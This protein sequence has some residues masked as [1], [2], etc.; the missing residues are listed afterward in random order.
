VVGVSIAEV[1]GRAGV[2]VEVVARV[3][4]GGD[5]PPDAAAAVWA[6]TRD[7]G[8]LD[9]AAVGRPVAGRP[10]TVAV[11]VSFT[12]RWFFTE[13]L[14]SVR[15]MLEWVGARTAIY[16]LPDINRRTMFFDQLPLRG[17]IDAVLVVSLVLTDAEFHTLARLG[18]PLGVLGVAVPGMLSTRIDDVAGARTAVEH[19]IG[20]GHER[21]ALIGDDQNAPMRYVPPRDRRAGYQQALTSA[22]LLV[23]PRL[24]V[25]GGF[26]PPGGARAAQILLDAP[27]PPSA[28]FCG[29]DEMAWGAVT[30]L[31]KRGLHVP[32]DV[33]V[34]G[35]DDHPAAALMDLS[36]IRQPVAAQA[37]DLT[38]RLLAQLAGRDA[39]EDEF[40]VVLPT[41]LVIRASTDLA[42]VTPERGTASPAVRG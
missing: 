12:D 33:A 31:V 39:G 10:V 32:H 11:L 16:H 15:A 34:I 17:D 9:W 8:F 23:D 38:T 7:V 6:A 41:E 36:T 1:A 19:L 18:V 3:L 24:D 14:S 30:T 35:Y 29:S 28:I 4:C 2:P 40:D 5:V 26:T 20:A 37:L 27:H 22:G 21:I 13:V 42:R 25:D